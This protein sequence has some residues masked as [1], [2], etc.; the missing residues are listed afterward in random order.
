MYPQLSSIS[1]WD[2]PWNKPTILDTPI[3]GN[4]HIYLK[5]EWSLR[6]HYQIMF[7][8]KSE[9]S[10]NGPFSSTMAMFVDHRVK[11][12]QSFKSPPTWPRVAHYPQPPIEANKMDE[13]LEDGGVPFRH[14]GYLS[15]VLIQFRLEFSLTK[16]VLIQFSSR[17]FPKNHPAINS[18]VAPL[19]HPIS[20]WLVLFR[21]E[22]TQGNLAIPHDDHSSP[23][24]GLTLLEWQDPGIPFDRHHLAPIPI[25]ISLG[26]EVWEVA[27][28][29]LGF[30]RIFFCFSIVATGH[31][32]VTKL[33]VDNSARHPSHAWTRSS[34]PRPAGLKKSPKKRGQMS[35][36]DGSPSR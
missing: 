16:S 25:P 2:L 3:D 9:S 28:E 13:Q 4:P 8:N 30:E 10:L 15:S 35:L 20:W 21:H 14:R 1:R 29:I 33:Q 6:K 32:G 7:S 22:A 11:V 36:Q 34:W 5:P 17:D 19:K 23:H 24:Q 26:G 18:G 27:T 12:D 31:W